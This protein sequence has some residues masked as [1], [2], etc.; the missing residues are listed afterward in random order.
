ML[1]SVCFVG[2]LQLQVFG[3]G[4]ARAAVLQTDP[5][6]AE[7]LA[8]Y[9]AYREALANADYAGVSEIA[10]G[11]RGFLA[12]RAAERLAR[13]SALAPEKRLRHFERMLELR[14]DDPLDWLTRRELQTELGQ[15][16]ELAGETAKAIEAFE[17]ALPGS[18]AVAGLRRLQTNPYRLSNAFLQARENR[19]ALDALGDL[20]APSIEAPAHAALRQNEEALDAYER[21]L[22]EVP[23]SR[24][25]LYGKAKMLYR[26]ERYT[27]A[28]ALFTQ[29][30]TRGAAYWR[31]LIARNLGQTSRAV[32][33]L[34]ESGDP[35]DIWLA[36]GLLE[37]E[38]R[39]AEAL[40]LYL[41]L[42]SGR[43]AYADDAAYRAVL[44]AERT[45]DAEA[46]DQAQSLLPPESFFARKLG[47]PL[48]LTVEN[49]LPQVVPDA[50]GLAN[51]LL[52]VDDPEAARG[53]L[54]F[55]LQG[56]SDR[57]SR[58]AI[59]EA[60]QA[61]GDYRQ[62]QRVGVALLDAGVRDE[63]AWQL[64]YPQAYRE[65]VSA[66]ATRFGVPAELVWAVMRQESAF[67]PRAVSRSNAKGLMQV[68]P[69]TWD[70]LAE[71]QGEA[72]G[73]PFD[74]AQNIR[75]GVF[76]LRWL[77]NFFSEYG[78]DPELIVTS[79]NRGQGYIRRLY[80][81]AA[82]Q[83]KDE[84]YRSIDALETRE[85]LQRVMTNFEIYQALY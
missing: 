30:G 61:L 76:Y 3:A 7:A 21:W 53:E 32:E 77:Q 6:A 12:Y 33:L 85:Y 47:A 43:S 58:L 78:G 15:L 1:V 13:E 71:L 40:P 66:E 51:A 80:E 64:A 45:G 44:L 28:E 63:R 74:P 50:V 81:G 25:A 46:S 54:L 84:L 39:A 10:F 42:A 62:S 52:Q 41:D 79:Y 65:Q 14:F 38:A 17:D 22:S 68:I 83:D 36:A 59:A 72:P 35:E 4:A 60:L 29:I 73:N 82:G 55:A 31:G 9:R 56:T 49:S 57:A 27:E 37:A 20:T 16:A 24:E 2:I 11:S 48:Q 26:L 67:F 19:L 69:S 34:L 5:Y 18:E 23:K 70:W 75:Y 8:P